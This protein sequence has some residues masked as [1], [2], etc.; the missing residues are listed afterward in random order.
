MSEFIIKRAGNTVYV[1]FPYNYKASKLIRTIPGYRYNVTTKQHTVPDSPS[2]YPILNEVKELF[3]VY[4]KLNKCAPVDLADL[5]KY[6]KEPCN[7]ISGLYP[8]QVECLQKL[9]KEGSQLIADQ[10]GYGK[11][12]EAISFLRDDSVERC[13]ALFIVPANLKVQ[14]EMQIKQW[15]GKGVRV[16]RLYGQTP[17]RLQCDTNYIINYEILQ[18]WE[19]ELKECEFKTIIV[20]ECVAICNQETIRTKVVRMLCKLPTT[21]YKILMSA[22]PWRSRISQLWMALNIIAPAEFPNFAEFQNMFSERKLV[23]KKIRG[24]RLL[25]YW[26]ERGVKNPNLLSKMLQPYVVRREKKTAVPTRI[27]LYFEVD[28]KDDMKFREA[29]R[30]AKTALDYETLYTNQQEESFFAKADQII[31]WVNS[32][33][34][35]DEKII[36]FAYNHSV[37]HHLEEAFGKK[38]VTISGKVDITKRDKIIEKFRK[39]VP[40]LIGQRGATGVGVDGLHKICRICCFVQLPKLEAEVG[41]CIGRL[42]RDGQTG[43]V[44]AY[45]PLGYDTFDVPA[46]ENLVTTGTM[47][48]AVLG[49]RGEKRDF[50]D[51][52]RYY[53]ENV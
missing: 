39:D 29:I 5:S 11:T 53:L 12:I 46:Y 52:F 33:I 37:I 21:R 42:D 4:E 32:I 19:K 38:C 27:P 15:M 3:E 22:T 43:Q 20:D 41:Q 34:A 24:G 44:L 8:A 18:H 1:N 49:T 10:V 26:E 30:R 36:L 45:F 17:T 6:Q 35:A 31:D 9:N 13:P 51:L 40:I 28:T 50:A 14:W 25:Q 2:T 47:Q 48:D 7:N 16:V 23:T